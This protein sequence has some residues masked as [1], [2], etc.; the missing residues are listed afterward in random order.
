MNL[1][2][3]ESDNLTEA[4]KVKRESSSSFTNAEAQKSSEYVKQQ[5][6]TYSKSFQTPQV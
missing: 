6:K 4:I 1:V 2:P 5:F 3:S